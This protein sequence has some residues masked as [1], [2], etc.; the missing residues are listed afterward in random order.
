MPKVCAVLI[1]EG[2][3][4]SRAKRGKLVLKCGAVKARQ[5][6]RLQL[7]RIFAEKAQIF[8]ACCEKKSN[9]I[10]CQF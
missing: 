8:G 2:F 3:V 1:V 5:A 6:D 10:T 7:N 4:F 9:E